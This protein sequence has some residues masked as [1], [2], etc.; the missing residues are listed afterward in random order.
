MT[1]IR[2][3]WIDDDSEIE[4]TFGYA[5]RNVQWIRKLKH[6]KNK[7]K[8]NPFVLDPWQERIIRKM[9]GPRNPDGSMKV[10]TT[11]LLLPRGNRKTSLAAAIVALFLFGPEKTPGNL[12]QSAGSA[13]KQA[14]ECYEEL[15]NIVNFDPRLRG[16]VSITDYKNR[17]SYRKHRTR[18]EAVSADAGVLHGGTPT[19]VF[20]DELHAWKKRDLWDV[21]DS[22]LNKTDD[23]IMVVAT[24]AGRG[25][26]NIAWE[27]YTYALKVQTGEIDD[28]SFLPVIF[29]AGKDADW[30]S[31]EVWHA[32]NP[33]L[34]HGYPS[35]KKLRTL[36]RK[37]EH[38]PGDRDVL[39]QLHL[40]VWLDSATSPFVDMAV[41][42][43]GKEPFD[44]ES[45]RDKPCW[46]GVDMSTTTDLTAVVACWRDG[47]G[48]FK[49]HPHF[50]CPE[51][52]IRLKAERDGVPYPHWAERGFITPTPGVTI[53]Q[54]AVE[55]YI[56]EFCE[57]FT[58]KEIAFDKA[59]ASLLMASLTKSH[60]PVIT[61]QQGW[62]TQ[63]PALNR[64]ETAILDGKLQHGG[65][66]VLRWNFSNVE[67][68]TD[69]AGNRTM[70]KGKSTD[71]IDGCFATW[72]ALDRASF[73]QDQ[74]NIYAGGQRPK[75]FATVKF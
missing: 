47:N 60:H 61:M 51:E 16:K 8:G 39:L 48:G 18:Y 57:R 55:R 40:N 24:T 46:L 75:G 69:A 17:I 70:H 21:L 7:A 34:K 50:F 6:P 65:H 59:Y 11:F 32:V 27:K 23:S 43:K 52:G 49:V 67:I 56:R 29:Q 58:V 31:E 22:S 42:D 33:G 1:T 68:A 15:A 37:A 45:L 14:R 30:R 63:S 5:E 38:S 44:I 41:Y 13:R 19:V 2:P 36:A 73:G 74:R 35:L 62:V 25:Q 12:I 72:M 9:F 53:D 4:D 54:D 26:E 64:L 3:S 71:R 20:V 28:P 66:P 10:Q